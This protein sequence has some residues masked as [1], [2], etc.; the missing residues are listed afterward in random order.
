MKV[1]RGK[2]GSKWLDEKIRTQYENILLGKIF[3]PV[4]P[5]IFC[6]N[7]IMFF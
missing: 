5:N 2:R 4:E 1:K 3:K 6:T 7:F